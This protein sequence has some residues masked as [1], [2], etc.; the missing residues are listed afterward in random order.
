MPVGGLAL[1]G[2]GTALVDDWE[3]SDW[4]SL[5]VRLDWTRGA[6]AALVSIAAR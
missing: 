4:P 2:S 1:L 5:L 3:S 6:T